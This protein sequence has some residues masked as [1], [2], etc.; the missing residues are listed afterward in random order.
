MN[1]KGKMNTNV[2]RN[3]ALCACLT[4]LPVTGAPV[5]KQE[6]SRA[7]GK[8][9][10]RLIEAVERCAREIEIDR[11]YITYCR[12]AMDLRVF[13]YPVN[14]SIPFGIDYNEISDPASAGLGD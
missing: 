4:A 13:P 6:F 11:E 8:M 12:S 1:W 10:T 9:H 3:V 5:T 7:Q 2:I 14:G